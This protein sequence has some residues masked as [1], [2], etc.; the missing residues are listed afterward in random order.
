MASPTSGFCWQETGFWACL[1]IILRVRIEP[2]NGIIFNIQR[3]SLHDGPGI[4]TTV[5]LKGCTL[6]CF[7]CH[8]P[9]G[10]YPDLEVQFTPERCIAD[11]DCA[12]ICPIQAHQFVDGVHRFDRARCDACG[13][14][15]SVCVTEALE[16][17]GRL[18]SEAEVMAEILSD[19]P[20]YESSGG[21]VT[22]SGGDPL[23][24]RQFSRALLARCRE[25]HIH[26]ALETAANCPWEH[27][28]ELLP[29][30]DLVMM[31]LKHMDDA[32]HRQAT[33]VSNQRLLDNARRMAEQGQRLIFR[34]PV[35]PGVND[36]LE[37]IVA[38]ASYV[39]DLTEAGRRNGHY[40]AHPPELELLPFHRLAEHKYRSLGR[41]NP[42]QHLQPP[43][44]ERLEA[45]TALAA[46]ILAGA[47][48]PVRHR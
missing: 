20:F 19:R 28:A 14:C 25:E 22:L 34:L 24:Q 31:D 27:L 46:D 2:V 4:R 48:V 7:W 17:S 42:A 45:L 13:E 35:I 26:T 8:N 5:F 39:R 36:T 30:T 41:A 40:V 38:T 15:V 9:E 23:V 1:K 32:Q 6:R 43:S 3:F 21:G 11:M 44:K 33:Q 12:R 47:D 10:M 37:N 29:L 16:L 18:V